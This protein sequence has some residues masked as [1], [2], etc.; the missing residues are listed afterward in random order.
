MITRLDIR[1]KVGE[2]AKIMDDDEGAHAKEDALRKL[3]L[4]TIATSNTDDPIGICMEALKTRKLKF[5]RWCA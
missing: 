2:I 1:K 4:K 5:A 3:V